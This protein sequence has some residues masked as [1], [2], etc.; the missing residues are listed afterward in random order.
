MYVA[1]G[2]VM[3]KLRDA[4]LKAYDASEPQDDSDMPKPTGWP[5][6]V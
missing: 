1:A 3:E 2:E 5:E 4:Y 6:S